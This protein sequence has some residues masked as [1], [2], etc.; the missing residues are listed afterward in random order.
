M[1]NKGKKEMEGK[2]GCKNT[3]TSFLREVGTPPQVH[4]S[5]APSILT[6]TREIDTH[7]A[8]PRQRKERDFKPQLTI[9]GTQSRA[10]SERGGGATERSA[11]R[12]GEAAARS[13]GGGDTGGGRQRGQGKLGRAETAEAPAP[14]GIHPRERERKRAG[15]AGKAQGEKQRRNIHL[16]ASCPL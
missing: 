1:L 4:A 16:P 6:H 12:E 2:V 7:R 15:K 3:E 10:G 13:L 8:H 14:Y 5:T 9:S 11:G